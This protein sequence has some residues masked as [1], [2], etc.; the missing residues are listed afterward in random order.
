M[1]FYIFHSKDGQP[2][3]AQDMGK[4]FRKACRKAKVKGVTLKD[5]RAKAATDAKK[6]GYSNEQDRPP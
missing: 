2:L 4:E 6:R 3:T 5:I 1:S